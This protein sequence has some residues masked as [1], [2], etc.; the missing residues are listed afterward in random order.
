MKCQF[1]DDSGPGQ[2]YSIPCEA[3]ATHVVEF[4]YRYGEVVETQRLC[5]DHAQYRQQGLNNWG[6]RY[7]HLATIRRE[8][9]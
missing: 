1:T 5:L 4:S 8:R 9:K 2:T 6:A 7:G 3:R